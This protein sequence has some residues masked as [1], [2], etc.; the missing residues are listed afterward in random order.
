MLA[1]RV[2]LP[3]PV[4]A[5]DEPE[6]AGAAGLHARE[7]VLEDGGLAGI[8]AEVRGAGEERVG[9]GLAR[10]AALAGDEA[11]DA[12]RRRGRSGR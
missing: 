8:D 2:G 4:H 1:Q 10:Q 11:V 12:R 6:T 3:D 5:D 7:G 9:R